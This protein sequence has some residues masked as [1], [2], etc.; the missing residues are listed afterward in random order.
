[1]AS[2]AITYTF[3]NSTTADAT[4]VQRTPFTVR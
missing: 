3:A 4:E 1:M 2:P